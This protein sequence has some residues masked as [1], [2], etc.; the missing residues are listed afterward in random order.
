MSSCS[1]ER[2]E[3]LLAITIIWHIKENGKRNKN[4]KKLRKSGKESVHIFLFNQ[5]FI[6]SI[7]NKGVPP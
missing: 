2:T 4:R 6:F 1:Q 7:W 5:F 3:T